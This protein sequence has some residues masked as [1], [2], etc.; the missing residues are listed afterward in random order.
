MKELAVYL[1]AYNLIRL[2]MLKAAKAQGVSVARISFVDA[3][4]WLLSR[5]L[6][7]SG[8]SR[9]IINPERPGRVQLRTVRGRRKKYVLLTMPRREA[10]RQMAGKSAEN[11]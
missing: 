8:V 6:G 1:I 11:A 2:A 3:E 10:E 5:I 9:L 7:L 4:R